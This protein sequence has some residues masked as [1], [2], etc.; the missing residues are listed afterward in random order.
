METKITRKHAEI[1]AERYA[2][3]VFMG[4]EASRAAFWASLDKDEREF[5]DKCVTSIAREWLNGFLEAIYNRNVLEVG[6]EGAKKFDVTFA[7]E[8]DEQGED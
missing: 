5:M 4:T 1:L 6:K 7:P 2:V 8:P 3:G